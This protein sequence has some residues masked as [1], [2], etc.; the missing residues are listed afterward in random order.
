MLALS[1]CPL[2]SQATTAGHSLASPSISL[3]GCWSPP[4]SLL[5]RE[6]KPRQLS[7]SRILRR[8]VHGCGMPGCCA[9]ECGMEGCLVP[10]RSWMCSYVPLENPP[11]SLPRPE[12]RLSWPTCLLTFFPSLCCS[13]PTTSD[14]TSGPLQVSPST[15]M[16]FPSSC[17]LCKPSSPSYYHPT[18]PPTPSSGPCTHM[19]L[20]LSL[21]KHAWDTCYTPGTVLSSEVLAVDKMDANSVLVV[22][23]HCECGRNGDDGGKGG[24]GAEGK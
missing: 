4:E 5:L 17:H 24:S 9:C 11:Q 10:G 23:T 13:H 6:P 21:S 19:T 16:S 2:P 14:S 12:A 3:P 18:F 7:M 22:L 20:S 1:L 15:C 8:C